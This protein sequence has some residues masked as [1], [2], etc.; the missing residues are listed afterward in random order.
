MKASAKEKAEEQ[1]QKNAIKTMYYTRY[2]LIRYV[3]TFFFFVNLY[4]ALMQ[5]LS[6]SVKGMFVPLALL[7]V[8]AIAMWEQFTMFTTEQPEAKMTKL[9]FKVTIIVNS[10]LVFATL[11]NQSFFLYPFFNETA[12]SKMVIIAI[13][14]LG[15]LL[16]SLMLVKINRIDVNKDKQFARINRYEASLKPS[17]H[18]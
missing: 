14:G 15:I 7:L 3:V 12:K 6:N 5:Y 2:F 16:A 13:A 1:R 18:Y 11:F 9:F 8:G 10:F 17:K 4:W